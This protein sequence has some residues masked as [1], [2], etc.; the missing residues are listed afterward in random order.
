MHAMFD[1]KR[2][3][4]VGVI[5]VLGVVGAGGAAYAAT[6][7]PTTAH[8]THAHHRAHGLLAHADKGTVEVKVHGSW[9]TYS[10]DRGKVTAA[11][12][13]SV[14]LAL[15]DGTSVT[16]AISAATKFRGVTSAAALTVGKRAVVVSQGQAAVRVAQ[17]A[18][19]ATP[20]A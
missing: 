7:S 15:P 20:A 9:V 13:T 2:K 14:T 10:I 11:S 3:V 6:P 8:K 19:T 1:V 12:A 18:A 17:R 5:G 16:E 4:A